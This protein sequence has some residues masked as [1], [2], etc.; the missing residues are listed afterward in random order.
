MSDE[1]LGIPCAVR[2]CPNPAGLQHSED[3][4]NRERRDGGLHPTYCHEVRICEEFPPMLCIHHGP[5]HPRRD[6]EKGDFYNTTR[7][8]LKHPHI[9]VGPSRHFESHIRDR[10]S[11]SHSSRSIEV[12][13]RVRMSPREAYR[14]EMNHRGL[15]LDGASHGY[16]GASQREVDRLRSEERQ[17]LP[18]VY[19]RHWE[20]DRRGR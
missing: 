1:C 19:Q 11:P 5:A 2:G 20:D 4:D 9:D 15:E 3:C 14:R 16:R 13:P 17:Q 18:G 6:R 12:L 8:I 7:P 10:R